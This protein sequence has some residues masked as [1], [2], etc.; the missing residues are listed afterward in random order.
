VVEN[1]A[2]A[3]VRVLERVDQLEPVVS[4]RDDVGDVGGIHRGW[5]ADPSR[6]IEGQVPQLD[7]Y[8][9]PRHRDSA[10]GATIIASRCASPIQKVSEHRGVQVQDVVVSGLGACVLD[11]QRSVQ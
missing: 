6:K 3:A 10:A 2:G 9:C 1:A 11:T 4:I 5:V 7:P 8:V